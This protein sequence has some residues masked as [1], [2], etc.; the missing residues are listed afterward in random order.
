MILTKQRRDPNSRVVTLILSRFAQSRGYYNK[1]D[2]RR[3]LLLNT[4]LLIFA[5]VLG[6][7]SLANIPKGHMA[8]AAGEFVAFILCLFLLYLVQS[9]RYLKLGSRIF[10][11]VGWMLGL[12]VC[13][14]PDTHP[15][16][17][18]WN[19]LGPIFAF[20]LLGRRLGL[21]AAIAM[22]LSVAVLFVWKYGAVPHTFPLISIL[23]VTVLIIGVAVFSYYYE[24][25][26][27]ETERALVRDIAERRRMEKEKEKLIYQLQGALAEVTNL[28]GLLPICSSCKKIRDD[29][30]YWN[31]IEAY[32]QKHSG[33]QFS[34]GICPDCA[35]KLYPEI[36][37]KS[38]DGVA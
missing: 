2:Y 27:S 34:H 12:F 31:Q 15:S 3:Y 13:A 30:G 7:F 28:S 19:T 22:L 17:F 21:L 26:R 20:L 35:Q 16:I 32:I 25:T 6:F 29:K 10:F 23:H 37:R 33:A 18:V 5:S 36:Y 38:D 14:S 9:P 8:V 4:S 11:V 1:T 24:F